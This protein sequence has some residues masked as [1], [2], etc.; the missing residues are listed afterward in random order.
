MSDQEIVKVVRTA[1]AEGE[2]VIVYKSDMVEG[3]KLYVEQAEAK[4]KAEAEAAGKIR[5]R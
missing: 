1:H 3:D 4:A 2:Y 5:G